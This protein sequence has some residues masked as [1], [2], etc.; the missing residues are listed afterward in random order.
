MTLKTKAESEIRSTYYR[1]HELFI[2]RLQ[3]LF[4]LASQRQI[5]VLTSFLTPVEQRI[6]LQQAPKNLFISFYGGYLNAIRKMACIQIQECEP[7][8][9]YV[10]LKG[11][12]IPQKRKC[13]HKDVLG[14]L[15][16]LGLQRN[17][18]GDIYV[19]DNQIL[20]VCKEGM[21]NF[22]CSECHKIAQ[23]FVHFKEDYTTDFPSACTETIKIHVASLRMDAIVAALGHCSRSK[24][25]DW[26][27]GGFVKLNDVVLEEND[28]L[29]NN[30]YVSIRKI[31]RFQF[32]GVESH[33]RKD[34]LVLRF[35]KYI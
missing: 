3:D 27:R 19:D 21:A 1:G 23:S 4:D 28:R 17:Q 20:L 24:A 6:V 31:G 14:A 26:I 10:I 30:D 2:A 22:I 16:H 18:I 7:D 12:Y 25:M 32:M 35:E 15:M 33:T 8:Y 5:P 34:R 29:C 13:T 9:D 11:S